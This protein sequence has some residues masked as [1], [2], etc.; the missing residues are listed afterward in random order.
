[1]LTF[2]GMLDLSCLAWAKIPYMVPILGTGLDAPSFLRWISIDDGMTN[3]TNALARRGN[4]CQSSTTSS[5]LN[6]F[7]SL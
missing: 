2:F 4:S 1:M 6:V 5:Q 3:E 7:K